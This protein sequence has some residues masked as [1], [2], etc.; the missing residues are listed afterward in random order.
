MKKVMYLM[1]VVFSYITIFPI[2]RDYNGNILSAQQGGVV[3]SSNNTQ[4]LFQA[5]AP[6]YAGQVNRRFGAAG[7]VSISMGNGGA[8]VAQAIALQSDGKMV[9]AGYAPVGG[10]KQFAIVRLNVDGSLDIS[11]NGTGKQLISFETGDSQAY[12]LA[13]QGDGQIVVAG[14]SRPLGGASRF[15]IARLMSNGSLDLLM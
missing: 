3:V 9:V 2:T 14:F 8:A 10:I 1:S 5:T 7:R 6:V 12:S 13:I 4:G 11:F 15:A